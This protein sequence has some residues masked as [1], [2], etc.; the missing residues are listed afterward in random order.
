MQIDYYEPIVSIQDGTEYDPDSSPEAWKSYK[1]YYANW[2]DLYEYDIDML[3]YYVSLYGK[4][5]PVAVKDYTYVDTLSKKSNR[6]V[7]L[8]KN[9]KMKEF[10]GKTYIRPALRMSGET[11]FDFKEDSKNKWRSKYDKFLKIIMSNKKE[12]EKA[13]QIE[14]LKYCK[15]MHHTILNFSLM[16]SLGNLQGLK[17][18]G[19]GDW[20]DRFDTFISMLDEYYST[21][22]N[23][24]ANLGI[25][26]NAGVNINGL[27][28]HL[29][30]F[31]DIFDYCE[32]V[33]FIKEEDFVLRIIEEGKQKIEDADDVERYMKLAID[34]WKMKLKVF[35]EMD[36]K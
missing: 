17:S 12:D 16:Q 35:K 31:D 10:K 28:G 3:R 26:I 23:E 4:K 7:A 24:K 6:L 2:K 20:L 14:T 11:D 32:K 36:A 1:K 29:D 22:E 9:T 27:Q 8:K 30:L 5:K 19:N 34:Y 18:R 33:Y 15:S 21:N 13:R 25:T